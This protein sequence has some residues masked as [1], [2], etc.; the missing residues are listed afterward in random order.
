MAIDFDGVRKTHSLL[1]VASRY[2]PDLK[3]RG[4]EYKAP[5]PFHADGDPSFTVFKCRD[6]LYRWHCFPCQTGGDVVDFVAGVE[7]VDSTEA[8]RRLTGGELPAAGDW[9]PPEHAPVDETD[10]WN[11]ILPVPADAPPYVPAHTFNP[12]RGQEVKYRP[13]RQDTYYDADGAILCHVV[14]LEIDGRKIC[15]TITFC[16]GPGGERRWCNK[17]MRAPYP[18]QGLDELARRPNAPVLIVSGEKCREWASKELGG[19]VVVSTLGGDDGMQHS[20]FT[21]LIGRNLTFWPDADE[22][23]R[24]AMGKLA[25]RIMEASANG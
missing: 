4:S 14:R 11:P 8:V 25:A 7:G 1:D 10:D 20:D 3:R 24:N 19:F 23:G 17:R 22:S 21:P 6:G 9:K 12:R 16:E 15:P 2:L 5:C 13:V 18:L